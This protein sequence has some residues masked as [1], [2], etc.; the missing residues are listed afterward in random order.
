MLTYEHDRGRRL[1]GTSHSRGARARQQ[2]TQNAGR[3]D[4]KRLGD[5]LQ[6]NQHEQRTQS[7]GD[8][9]DVHEGPPS[10]DERRSRDGPG[11][12]GGHAVD[13]CLDRPILGPALE[14]RRG[15]HGEQVARQEGA[16]RG[17]HGAREAGHEVPDEAHRDDDRAG[18]DHRHRHRVQELSLV[19]PAELLDDAAVKEGHDG[20]A[21]AEDERPGLGEVPAD[22]PQRRPAAGRPDEPG[23]QA[24]R[25][26]PRPSAVRGAPA[27]GRLRTSKRQGA[28][29]DEDPHDLR[30][31]PRRDEAGGGEERSRAGASRPRVR[32]V[33]LTALRAMIAMTAAP[34]P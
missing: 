14:M 19:Q 3:A 26:G 6:A 21:A 15:D 34:I 25:A 31:R 23:E 5:P 7:D 20:E 12:G 11:G 22:P 2:D 4:E 10:E 17:D 13:E 30:L 18:R 33:S 27:R 8:G 28:R 16:E 9:G 29:S 32:R 24:R 1:H